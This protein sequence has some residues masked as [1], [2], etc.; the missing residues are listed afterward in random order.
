MIFEAEAL[1][2]GARR[3]TLFQEFIR[4]AKREGLFLA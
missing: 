3:H 1:H 2:Q 4:R